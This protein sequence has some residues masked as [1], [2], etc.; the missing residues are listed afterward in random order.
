MSEGPYKMGTIA[1]LSG[2]SPEL[3][4]AWER[5]YGLLD[6][7]RGSGGQRLYGD[8]DLRVLERVRA[9]LSEGRS[10]GEVA[11]VGRAR[12]LQSTNGGAGFSPPGIGP[13]RSRPLRESR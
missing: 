4:R 7:S 6:P 11:Q 1:R 2:F 9:L 8:D 3:L 5:R 10:I 13:A 12:L